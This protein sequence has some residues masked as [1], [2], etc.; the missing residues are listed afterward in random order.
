MLG[1]LQMVG[2]L[3]LVF[4]VCAGASYVFHASQR[5]R[6]AP[7]QL[8]ENATVRMVGSGGVYRC[9]YLRESRRGLVFSAPIQRDRYVPIREGESMVIQAPQDS[10][11]LTF[12]TT[13]LERDA[14]T[15]EF[16]LARPV[17]IRNIDRRT[18]ERDTS[19][20]GAPA[21]MNGTAATIVNL[22]AG[23]AKVITTDEIDPGDQVRL[24]LPN[25]LGEAYGWALDTTASNRGRIPARAVRIRF[26]MP[27]S[28]LRRVRTKRFDLG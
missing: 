23:G 18:E 4:G 7:V 26:S 12:R 28:G 10:S 6:S 13:V 8:A 27:L 5:R 2:L 14:E 15:H 16:I 1:Y 24:E 22:S 17:S 3:A 25:G 19:I 9:H 21:V 20:D 11:L